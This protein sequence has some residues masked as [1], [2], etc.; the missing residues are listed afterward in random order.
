MRVSVYTE[1]IYDEEHFLGMVEFPF[2]DI[3]S[4]PNAWSI[5]KVVPLMGHPDYKK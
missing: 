3:E 2:Q 4:K 5:N 1:R